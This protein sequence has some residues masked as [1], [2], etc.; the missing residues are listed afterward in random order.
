MGYTRTNLSS[1]TAAVTNRFVT[2]TNMK[3][4]A[5]TLANTSA[6]WSGGF[7]VTV[8]SQVTACPHESLAM[9]VTTVVPIG[10]VLP[11][12][13][14]Q[15]AVTGQQ[16]GLTVGGGKFT[17]AP[18]PLVAVTV[19]GPPALDPTRKLK[20]SGMV[21]T[22]LDLGARVALGVGP[23]LVDLAR[24]DAELP[25]HRPLPAAEVPEHPQPLARVERSF[26]HHAE[27]LR[28]RNVVRT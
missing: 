10:K 3:V 23:Q 28:L 8:N 15:T 7:T 27:Q 14:L 5:Y 25:G 12:G 9:Q 26:R 22:P 13:G 18:A 16:P 4:G 11:L 19:Q 20:I 6:A 17:T 21:K 24:G 2:S 1:S